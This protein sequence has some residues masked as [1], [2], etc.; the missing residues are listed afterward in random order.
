MDNDPEKKHPH[1]HG[2]QEIENPDMLD[3]P[4]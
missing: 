1:S 3:Q 2:R 4:V